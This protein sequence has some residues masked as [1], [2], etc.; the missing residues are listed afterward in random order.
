MTVPSLIELLILGLA[1]YRAAAFLVL[2]DMPFGGFREW[3]HERRPP[4]TSAIG[5][6]WTCMSCMSVWTTI[7]TWGAW[8]LWPKPALL[9]ATPFAIAGLARALRPT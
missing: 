3:L 6:L 2:D 4:D 8:T 7:I 1:A 5:Y 9:A